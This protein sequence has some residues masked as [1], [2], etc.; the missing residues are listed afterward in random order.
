VASLPWV[1]EHLALRALAVKNFRRFFAGDLVSM[2]GGFLQTITLV[3]VVLDL[4]GNAFDVAMLVSLQNL[5]SLVL[6][7]VG[8]TLA[9]RF[10]NRKLLIGLQFVG[11]A[12][13]TALGVLSATGTITLGWIYL[14]AI[15]LGLFVSFSFPAANAMRYEVVEAEDL[16]SAIGLGSTTMSVGRLVGPAV[17]GI[18]LATTD[19]A[20]CFFVDASTFLFFVV[21]LVLI[22]PGE[23]RP[24]RAADRTSVKLRDGLRYAWERPM[25]R[26]VLASV[27]IVSMLAYNLALMIPAMTRIEF[28]GSSTAY[29][30]VATT[31]GLAGLIGGVAAAGI[32]RPSVRIFGWLGIGFGVP[33]LASTFSPLV[34]VFAVF[35]LGV[36][37]ASAA[38]WAVAQMLLQHGTD[39][40]YQGRVMSLYTV[41]WGG[42]T[43]F[44]ALAMGALIDAVSARAAMAVGGVTTLVVAL[45]LL[46]WA[47]RERTR[48]QTTIG[49]LP[50]P[51]TFDE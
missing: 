22:R 7:P 10:D 18:L 35:F 31:T 27:A 20:T 3:W 15:V 40:E 21:M 38:F 1:R 49:R 50:S 19:A 37:F 46:R 43:I 36:G 25:L 42:T 51:R 4:G 34:A 44:G 8:G 11:V 5:P 48:A 28:G 14:L 29:A 30:V 12:E 39:P 6:A 23:L 26:L 2:C 13:A 24:R 47:R 45:V 41:A 9:D 32:V 33:L 16:S 17:A